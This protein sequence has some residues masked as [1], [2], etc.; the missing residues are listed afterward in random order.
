MRIN[1]IHRRAMDEYHNG[2]HCKILVTCLNTNCSNTFET[3]LTS[4]AA[5]NV[6]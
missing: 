2:L 6:F 3:Y 1:K 4:I 5:E